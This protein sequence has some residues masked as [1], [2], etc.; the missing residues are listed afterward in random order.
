MNIL[1]SDSWLREFIETK[2]TPEQIRESLSLCSQSVEKITKVGRDFV[3]D[4]E[5]TTN[6][7]DCLS[8]YGLARELAAILPRV[9]FQ[10][11]L[12]GVP[13]A[14]LNKVTR[15]LPLQVKINN[16]NLCPRFTSLIFDN[17][18]IKPSPDLVAKRIENSGI[19]SLNNVIDISNYLMLELG[20]PMH[21]FDYDKISG[22]KMI[23]R[24]A[25]EGEEIETLDG[26]KRPLPEG[27]IVI[28][29]GKGRVIDLCG[30]MGGKN[31]EVD[32]STK[33]VLLFVQTY[34]PVR[35]RRTC[36]ALSF[37]TEAASR[38]E[39]GVDP[40]GV[41]L[42]MK[43]ATLLFKEW[44]G[45][46]VASHL[47]DIY[48]H[49]PKE[50]K[51]S[52][53]QEKLNSMVGV[54]IKISVVKEIL[55]NLG[56]TTKAKTKNT[57]KVTV[58][59]WRADDIDIPEDLVEEVARIY[60]YHNLPNALPPLTSLNQTKNPVFAWEDKIK[61]ALKFWGF[62]ETLTYSLVSQEMLLMADLK[63]K[64]HL[65]IANPLT[66]TLVY[67]RTTLIPSLL[68][69]LANNA[70]EESI[71]IFEMANIYPPQGKDQLPDER[72]K[73]SIAA[74]GEQFFQL[75]GIAEALLP[76]LGIADYEFSE[77]NISLPMLDKTKVTQILVNGQSV[78][79]LGGIN[80]EILD[81]FG[82][83]SLVTVLDLE[84]GP[85]LKSASGH[86][87]YLPASKYPPIIEDLSFEFPARTLVGPVIQSVKEVSSLIKKVDLIDSYENTR[88]FRIAYQS[89]DKNLTDKEIKPLR[90]KIIKRLSARFQAQV[91]GVL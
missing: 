37:R 81:R 32:E 58:P 19:R 52:F 23:L 18:Q 60:G 39:K 84:L 83:K 4:I 41:G 62:T 56:F 66:K 87:K 6:R 65:K 45:A 90:E 64:D 46:R 68:Q 49:P 8:V 85:L 88:T 21:T 16:Q 74:S 63:T 20:Q 14:T 50:K 34:D 53:S 86:K 70:T 43:R 57:L 24:E 7:P 30:I 13:V 11:K 35:I 38:F 48:P 5:I 44:C 1:I 17:V 51:I 25:R 59:H 55:E 27:T 61:N 77:A 3:Y 29:D 79:V 28:E 91:K 89:L 2:A 22:A 33:R 15:S 80:Q 12:K 71:K 73:L 72:M 69:I 36:Q 82:I 78:G 42:A 10:A 9:G 67:L 75:K 31:S 40:E 54:E 76:E 26:Q 47:T